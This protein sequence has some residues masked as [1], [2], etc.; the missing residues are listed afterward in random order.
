MKTHKNVLDDKAPIYIALQNL[1]QI[2]DFCFNTDDT[3]IHNHVD[4]HV[5]HV[6]EEEMIG[7]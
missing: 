6:P 1:K 3:Y 5:R 2:F 7:K 4:A